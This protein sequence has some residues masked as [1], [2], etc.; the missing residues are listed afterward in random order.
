MCPLLL[1]CRTL[2][3]SLTH[4][5]FQSSQ[6][7]VWRLQGQAEFPVDEHQNSCYLFW[8]V[9]YLLQDSDIPIRLEEAS[10]K[11]VFLRHLER[12]F[13]LSDEFP[14]FVICMWRIRSLLTASDP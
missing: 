5:A 13:Q 7:S 9:E 2:R 1:S 10:E 8:V 11:T 3:E 12:A 14:L 6:L 4:L